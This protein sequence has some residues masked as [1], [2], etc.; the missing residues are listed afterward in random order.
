MP[1]SKIEVKKATLKSSPFEWL[2]IT[3]VAGRLKVHRNTV[4]NMIKDGRL[5]Y[6]MVMRKYYEIK[7]YQ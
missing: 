6:R 4:I 5:E 2:S 7:Y 3:E 1:K